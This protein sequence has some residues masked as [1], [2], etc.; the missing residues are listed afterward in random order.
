MRPGDSGESKE[1]WPI[2]LQASPE[3]PA[4]SMRNDR[5]LL[6]WK[7]FSFFVFPPVRPQDLLAS[8]GFA[9]ERVDIIDSSEPGEVKTPVLLGLFC[10]T[11][12]IFNWPTLFSSSLSFYYLPL[13]L[14]YC[15]S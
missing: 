10:A 13:V 11:S 1:R 12:L 8:T 2:K 4:G 15:V 14:L 7:F 3:I 9:L 5:H 6:A